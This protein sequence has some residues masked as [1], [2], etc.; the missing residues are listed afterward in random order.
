[1][2]SEAHSASSEP[3]I[4]MLYHLYRTAENDRK[5]MSSEREHKLTTLLREFKQSLEELYGDRLIHL[6]LYGS[7]ARNQATDASDI[8]ILVVLKDP[9]SVAEE[10]FRMGTIKTILNL[11]YD[12]LISVLP[13]S[14]TEYLHKTTPLLQNIRQEGIAV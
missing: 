9:V 1:L 2:S 4:K 5:T 8:D 3:D 10:I 12:E 6:I 14:Q 11:K 7:Y 13:I